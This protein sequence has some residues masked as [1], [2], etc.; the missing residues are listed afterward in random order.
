MPD[1]AGEVGSP[2]RTDEVGECRWSEG[3]GKLKSSDSRQLAFVFADNP[4]GSEDDPNADES[5]VRTCLLHQ[6]KAKETTESGAETVGLI[7]RLER[8]AS[9]GNLSRTLLNV[10]RN[11]GAP[12]VDEQSVQDVVEHALAVLAALQRALIAGTYRSGDIRRVWIPKSCDGQRGLGIPNVVDRV[13]QQP[14]Y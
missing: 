14:V 13:V 6:A 12:G 4:Q 5:A 2:H 8:A 9:I 7:R 10:A 3:G 1:V 11:K